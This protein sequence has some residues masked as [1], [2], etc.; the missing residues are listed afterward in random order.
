MAA[1]HPR[2]GVA[3][4][5]AHQH[6][7]TVL[8]SRGPCNKVIDRDADGAVSKSMAKNNGVFLAQTAPAPDIAAMADV[9]REVGT[10]PDCTLSLGVFKDAPAE[11]FVVL[12]EA[13]LAKRLGVDPL[14]RDALKGF[15]EIDGKPTVARLKENMQFGSWLLFDRDCVKGMPPELADLDR[16]AWLAAM[17]RLVPGLA[18][19][20]RILLPSTSQRVVVDGAPMQSSSYHLFLQVIDPGE[21]PR[22][23]SQLLPKSFVVTIEA[24]PREGPV[25]LGFLRPKYSR[26]D[27]GVVVA[28][29]PWTIFDP[30]TASPERLVFDGAPVIG[31]GDGLKVRPPQLEISEGDALDLSAFEDLDQASIPEIEKRTRTTVRL[32]R[33]GKGARARVIGVSTTSATLS[34]ELEIETERG[35]TTVN[36]LHQSG[37]GKTRCQSPFRESSSWAAYYNV[38]HDGKP[39]IF[40]SGTNTK[41]V[42]RDDREEIRCY[43]G[44]LPRN[45]ADAE[46]VL[47]VATCREPALGVY[48]RGG[49]LVRIARLPVATAA[50]GIRRAAGSMQILPAGPDFLRLRL[51]QIAI[52]RKFDK[53]SEEWVNTD[54]PAAVSRALADIAGM[55]SHTRNLA[56]IIEAPALR[57][58]GIILERPGFDPDSG[59]YLDPGS[60]KFPSIPPRP[61]RREAEAALAKLLEIIA[62]FPFVDEA[63]KSVALALLI[64]PLIRYAV[65]AAPLTGISAPKMGSGKTLLSH[66]PAYIA[67]GRAPALMAQADDPNEEKKRLL[68]LLLEGSLVTVLDNCERPL[69][70]DSLCTALTEVVIRDRILGST[71]TISVPTATTWIATGNALSIDGDLSSRTLLCTLDP[72]CERPEEREFT[73]DL[74]ADVPH[75]RGEL[76]AA[77]LTIVKA[78][79]AADAPRQKIPT[80]GRFE[81]WSRFAREPLVWL[82]CADPCETRRAIEARDPVRDRLSN[83]LEAWHAVFGDRKEQTVA[84]AIQATE[85]EYIVA[86]ITKGDGSA[87]ALKALRNALEAVGDDRGK[88]SARWIGKFLSK[89][90]GRIERGYRADQAGRRTNAVLWSV[91]LVSLVSSSQRT[92]KKCQSPPQE[93][94]SDSFYRWSETNSPNSPNSPNGHHWCGHCGEPINPGATGTTTTSGGELLHNRCVDAW[95]RS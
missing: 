47:G 86:A 27:P 81:A 63:S 76:A 61:T 58:D 20:G 74:H 38:F 71:R 18:Q 13:M 54:A 53:R 6:A 4:V 68:A 26:T 14:D 33:S 44:S 89:H 77:A 10:H 52:W 87:D 91:S 80:F 85:P 94:S 2:L 37:A 5:S 84:A 36:E 32:K 60:T 66:L 45:V 11:P 9:L 64:T 88:L 75:R 1:D 31:S 22:I 70:S 19:A 17:D 62:G 12:P 24:P 56:G 28:W 73:V 25:R 16:A 69:K 35:W 57:P 8:T 67:T 39:F 30:S 40:D 72:K 90:E 65:R 78:F 82:G 29:Q 43:G 23:W 59:L 83:L 7:V 55:W 50:D 95:S 79:L 46:R 93:S 92:R 15:H 42:L 21:I 48:Q 51:T 41:Y 34:L 3:P 49:I